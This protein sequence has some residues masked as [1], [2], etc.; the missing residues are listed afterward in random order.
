NGT[1]IYHVF[2]YSD[3]SA[4]AFNTGSSAEVFPEPREA[5]IDYV[6]LHPGYTG[7][8]AGWRPYLVGNNFNHFQLWTLKQDGTAEET[9]N[10]IGRHELFGFL[11][12]ARN[13]DFNLTFQSGFPPAASN[14]RGLD[15]FHQ[16]HEDP[17]TPGTYYGIDCR[18]F[19]T[20]ASGQIVSITGAPSLNGNEMVVQYV[21]HRET[22]AP[23]PTPGP[24][25]SGFY[26]N[27]LPLA[28]GTIVAAHTKNTKKELDQGT[29]SA[30]RSRFD[31][32]LKTLVQGA[33]GFLVAGQ[34]LTG[35]I[36]KRVQYYD[37]YN[38]LT[39][40]GLLWEL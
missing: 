35:G 19:D 13:D 34:A 29:P 15:S 17:L 10:H 25:H 20:H 16:V 12:P 1:P 11:E 23:T 32:R 4:S 18:E 39:Y 28:D 6:A 22:Q 38:L 14:R 36:R 5:W 31:F 24:N 40:D 9:L 2:N 8:P 21:T 30:P 37:P 26:R 7:D 27:P 3:E 33:N